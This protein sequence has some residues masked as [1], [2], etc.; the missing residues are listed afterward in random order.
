MQLER[1][2]GK[3][4]THPSATEI[5]DALR[6]LSLKNSLAILSSGEETY[7]QTSGSAASGLSV[8]YRAG[9][10][11]SHSQSASDALPLSTV[12][13]MF[14][15]YSSGDATWRT[16]ISWRSSGEDTSRSVVPLAIGIGIIVIGLILA[17]VLGAEA[18]AV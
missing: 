13:E 4:L 9:S 2:S 14:Q 8:E 6:G 1:E 17:F 7:I 3:I 10:E 11:E 5:E 16:R 12:V 18:G 15:Q